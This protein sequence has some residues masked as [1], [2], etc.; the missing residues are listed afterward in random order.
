MG[1]VIH[2]LAAAEASQNYADGSPIYMSLNKQRPYASPTLEL[3]LRCPEEF[4]SLFMRLTQ[5]DVAKG[6]IDPDLLGRGG[7][8][9]WFD[10]RMLV[11]GSRWRSLKVP[12]FMAHLASPL[13]LVEP[14]ADEAAISPLFSDGTWTGTLVWDSAVHVCELMLRSDEWRRRVR[15]ARV[16]ELGCGLGLPG[17]CA[18]LMGARSV[19][20]TDR[21]A[22]A[23]LV[24]DARAAQGSPSS[25]AVAEFCWSADGAASLLA[26]E[27]GGERPG[28][29][30]ACDCIFAPLFGDA[31][32]LLQMLLALAGPD[33]AVIIGI[34]RRPA[35][36]APAFFTQAAEAG[37]DTTV[38]QQHERVLV[39]EMRRGPPRASPPQGVLA[40]AAECLAQGLRALTCDALP[41]P[42]AGARA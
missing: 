24:E 13:G 42:G 39:C 22:I 1:D 3:Q 29:I 7:L 25:V 5:K 34:E 19:L 30:I 27:L 33:T 37:F 40:V 35:D 31:F 20:L 14:E 6:C 18:H 17:W 8:R 10:V 4:E 21:G 11:D 2:A 32:L 36:G 15:G 12:A 38:L 26:T 28:L 9:D 23:E 16:L 41:V